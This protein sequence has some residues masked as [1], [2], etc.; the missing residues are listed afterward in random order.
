LGV[1]VEPQS[2]RFLVAGS[3]NWEEFQYSGPLRERR[4]VDGYQL[5]ISNSGQAEIVAY[6][7]QQQEDDNPVPQVLFFPT[8]EMNPFTL[9]FRH[10]SLEGSYKLQGQSNG[11]MRLLWEE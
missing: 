4:L 2:Y 3:E 11:R 10:Y 5:V 1:V 8:G 7:E 6:S 9:S